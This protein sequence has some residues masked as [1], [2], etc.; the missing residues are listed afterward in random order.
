MDQL[1]QAVAA[2]TQV[3][4]EKP[5]MGY[6]GGRFE[7][8]SVQ[9]HK[10]ETILSLLHGQEPAAPA[11]SARPPYLTYLVPPIVV[12][13]DFDRPAALTR[14]RAKKR[15]KSLRAVVKAD[16]SCRR[17]VALRME[18]TRGRFVPSAKSPGSE[19]LTL[20]GSCGRRSDATPKMR[21]GPGGSRTLCNACGLMWDKTGKLRGM[22]NEPC[23]GVRSRGV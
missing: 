15:R 7:F 3:G 2:E 12:P 17:D 23:G 5:V 22:E 16:Y 8:D 13:P 19:P 18:R 11:E 6:D 21:R 9:P 1:P 10:V 14:Y 20:C 4:E